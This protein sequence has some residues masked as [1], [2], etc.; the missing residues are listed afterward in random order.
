MASAIVR[1]MQ[2]DG[3]YAAAQLWKLDTFKGRTAPISTMLAD[4]LMLPQF[5]SARF[6]AWVEQYGRLPEAFMQPSFHLL[7]HEEFPQHLSDLA[8]VSCSVLQIVDGVRTWINYHGSVAQYLSQRE[9]IF[10]NT[11]PTS[12]KIVDRLNDEEKAYFDEWYERYDCFWPWVGS[13]RRM[14]CFE[15]NNGSRLRAHPQLLGLYARSRTHLHDWYAAVEYEPFN[16]DYS[17]VV[18]DY[19]GGEVHSRTTRDATRA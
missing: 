14:S 1:P 17:Y 15:R 3:H 19:R 13:Q 12:L 11:V 5:P 6:K 9:A 16:R 18:V 10:G 8:S 2:L 7:A 4:Y